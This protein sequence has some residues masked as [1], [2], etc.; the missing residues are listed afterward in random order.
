MENEEVELFSPMERRG[1]VALIFRREKCP[2]RSDWVERVSIERERNGRTGG[3]ER[4]GCERRNIFIL[5]K[6]G[7]RTLCSLFANLSDTN[8]ETYL[9]LKRNCIVQWDCESARWRM[10]TS[11]L[12]RLSIDMER[13]GTGVCE[14]VVSN[15]FF[16]ENKIQIYG[17]LGLKK[18]LRFYDAQ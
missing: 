8:T 11:A 3:C 7:K 15:L 16:K 12:S 4:E 13:H 2:E 6:C 5:S 10:S 18:R 9:I 1:Q 14:H 17:F